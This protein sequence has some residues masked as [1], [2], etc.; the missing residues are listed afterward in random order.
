MCG[1]VWV[2]DVVVCVREA[3]GIRKTCLK[4]IIKMY[5]KQ[6]QKKGHTKQQMGNI[7]INAP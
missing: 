2:G 6:T 5:T 3:S 1:G 7:V 4:T